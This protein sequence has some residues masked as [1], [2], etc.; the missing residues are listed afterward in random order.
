MKE[1]DKSMQE[2]IKRRLQKETE[3]FL[4]NWKLVCRGLEIY[5]KEIEVYYY[6]KEGEFKDDSVHK[7]DLQKNNRNHFYV[8]RWGTKSSDS[9]KGGSRTGIDFVISDNENIYQSYLIRSAEINGET[10]VGPNKVLKKIIMACDFSDEHLESNYKELE[11]SPVTLEPNN[12]SADVLFS[13]RMN[14]KKGYVD[15]ELRAVLCDDKFI[16]C[17]YPGKEK[18]IVDFLSEKV[19]LQDMTSDE[20]RKYAKVKLNYI[21]SEIKSL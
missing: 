18:M 4:T 5:P 20:A 14:L 8:H 19:H 11:C 16:N 7:N 2:Q 10:I 17:K 9:Y 6:E 15:C 13:K 3:H 21:P 12:V 1:K